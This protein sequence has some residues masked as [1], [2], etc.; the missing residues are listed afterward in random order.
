M[1][2][3]Q[4]DIQNLQNQ[5]EQQTSKNDLTIE[6]LFHDSPVLF[7]EIINQDPSVV[8]SELNS[9]EQ[10]SSNTEQI[11]HQTPPEKHRTSQGTPPPPKKRLQ[12]LEDTAILSSPI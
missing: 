8:T 6:P 9:P 3:A 1:T 7:L 11:E 4:L 10:N 5:L 12:I 2:Q